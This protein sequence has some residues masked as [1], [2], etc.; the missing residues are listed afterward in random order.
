MAI[1]DLF[2]THVTVLN[3]GTATDRYGNDVDDWTTPTTIETSGWLQ[4]LIS[5]RPRPGHGVESLDGRDTLTS[6]H[7]LFLPADVAI[8]G[9]SRVVIDGITFE[10]DGPPATARTPEGPHHLE[11]QLHIL[12]D[13]HQGALS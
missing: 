13:L 2:V 9:Y 4:D 5:R 10:V 8:S 12:E 3:P 1:E 6:P 7:Q 11:V